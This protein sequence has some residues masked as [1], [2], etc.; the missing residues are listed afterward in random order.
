MFSS[1]SKFADSLS[2]VI[3]VESFMSSFLNEINWFLLCK[4]SRNESGVKYLL[5]YVKYQ[6]CFNLTEELKPSAI[7]K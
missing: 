3:V 6:C 4:I 7:E 1:E 2:F 5:F